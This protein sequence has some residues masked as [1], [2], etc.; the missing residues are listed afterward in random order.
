MEN[1]LRQSIMEAEELLQ[2]YVAGEKNFKG[3]TLVGIDLTGA[4]LSNANFTRANLRN[5]ILKDANIIL[6]SLPSC[7]YSSICF[8]HFSF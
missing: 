5:V 6:R 2:Q 3:I 7:F 8:I 4:D 1:I